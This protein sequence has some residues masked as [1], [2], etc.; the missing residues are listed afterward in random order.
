MNLSISLTNKNIFP[1]IAKTLT[2]LLLLAIVW[3]VGKVIN[4]LLQPPLD[5]IQPALQKEPANSSFGSLQPAKPS[6]ILGELQASSDAEKQEEIPLKESLDALQDTKL[7]VLLT[8]ILYTPEDSVAVIEENRKTFVLR[9]GEELRP[10]ISIENIEPSFV[11]LDN[12]GKLEKLSLK[13]SELPVSKSQSKLA[14]KAISEDDKAKLD[15]I[16]SDVRKTPLAMNR[17]VRFRNL[18]RDGK[19]YALQVWPRKE[20]A[21]FESLGFKSGDKILSVDGTAISEMNENPQQ[22]Q[23]LM[24]KTQFSLQIER[25]GQI[26]SL[27]VSL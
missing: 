25:R 5:I 21:L 8:G 2:V 10:D 11:V 27:S 7:N 22:L 3:V 12:R 23:Q 4:Q 1:L 19:V 13:E 9:V 16:R 18:T 6:F 17:Y 24:Q 14:V 15:K 20:R 26:Q